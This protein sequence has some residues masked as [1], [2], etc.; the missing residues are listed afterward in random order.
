MWLWVLDHKESWAW[1]KWC[2]WTVMLEKTL[3]NPL[4]SK[5]IKLV[6][7]KGYQLWPFIERTDAEAESPI[8]ATW[9]E[10]LTQW[11]RPWCGNEG[12]RRRGWQSVR[13]GWMASPNQW[14]WV[15]ATSG[16]DDGQGVL[17]CCHPW[18]HRVGHNWTSELKQT[19]SRAIA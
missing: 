19:Q 17:A 7:P 5:E 16:V 10:E 18:S 6:N 1:K 8:L 13:C 15:W 14:T 2:F 3:E 12:R 4:D 11:K 9:Y